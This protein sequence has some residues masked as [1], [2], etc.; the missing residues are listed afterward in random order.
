MT[1]HEV[2]TRTSTPAIL[3]SRHELPNKRP[4]GYPGV[5]QEAEY[6]GECPNQPIS[7]PPNG[8][9]LVLTS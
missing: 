1:T 5:A 3:P 4:L 8:G 6:V 7:H 2:S 9:F